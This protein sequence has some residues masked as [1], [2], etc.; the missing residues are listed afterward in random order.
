[1]RL[2]SQRRNVARFPRHTIATRQTASRLTINDRHEELVSKTTGSDRQSLLT[3]A[4]GGFDLLVV[5]TAKIGMYF[6]ILKYY[7]HPW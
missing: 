6:S 7:R 2:L 5:T 3:D 1:M 4:S